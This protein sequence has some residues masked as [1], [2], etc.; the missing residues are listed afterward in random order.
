MKLRG[1]AALACISLLALGLARTA[2]GDGH[3]LGTLPDPSATSAS[4]SS[5]LSTE[6]IRQAL[7]TV[8]AG[9]RALA[10]GVV[11]EG[12]GRVLTSLSS[13]GGRETVDVRYA[14]SH[15]AHARVM[16]KDPVLD[17]ALLVPQSG[18]Y[19]TG[20]LASELDA[21]TVELRTASLSGGRI[22]VVAA[23]LKGRV[24]AHAKDGTFLS[25]AY[26]LERTPPS[27]APLLDPDGRALG[28]AGHACKNLDGGGPACSDVTVVVPILSIRIFLSRTPA[29]AVAP[30]AW[31]GINGVSDSVN[32]IRGV[33]V[34]AVAPH[35]PAEHSGL[36]TTTDL[37]VVADGQPL[38]T[39]ERLAEI[40]AK[41]AVGD[42][43]KLSVFSAGRY[44]EV[45]VTLG[46]P[47]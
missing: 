38:D 31:L 27:G 20:L 46:A 37:I 44:R 25:G 45:N 14:N 26:E 18:R 1:L 21:S 4:P 43:L 41:H 11:L 17:L 13:L 34:Q 23:K 47:P 36:H 32:G 9:G 2:A 8:E 29:S 35:S 22:G 24:D 19:T 33:R 40:V 39:P 16:H 42:T 28:I 15:T 10:V 12:D 30:S 6:R 7:V 5:G 3:P